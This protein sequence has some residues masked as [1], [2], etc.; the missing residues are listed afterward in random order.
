MKFYQSALFVLCNCILLVSCDLLTTKAN[1]DDPVARVHNSFLYGSDLAGIA[2]PGINEKDSGILIRNY[3]DNWARQQ[4]LLNKANLNLSLKDIQP[5]L[6]K[7]IEDYKVSLIIH[8]YKQELIRQQLDTIISGVQIAE[9][10]NLHK[11]KLR[12]G[13]HAMMVNYIKVWYIMIVNT[14]LD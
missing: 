7:Q 9:Y 8:A 5:K 3:I 11:D 6:D 14:I 10:Y 2:P 12:L 1:G 4:L 13:N